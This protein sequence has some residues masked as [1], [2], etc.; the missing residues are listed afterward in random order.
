MT[1]KQLELGGLA[2]PKNQEPS[3]K[4]DESK[5]EAPKPKKAKPVQ[6]SLNSRPAKK[7]IR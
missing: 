6:R 2:S 3:P 5:A 4:P 1:Q 7:H